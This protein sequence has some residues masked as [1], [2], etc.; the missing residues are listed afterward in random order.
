MQQLANLFT[1]TEEFS[2]T[3]GLW[4]FKNET[5]VFTNG[6]FDLLHPGHVQYLTDARALGSKLIVGLNTDASV[7]RQNKGPERPLQSQEAR[8]HILL[9]LRSVS[10]VI[11]FDDDTPLDLIKSI[12]PNILVKGAD[13]SVEATPTDKDYIVGKDEVIA[14]G[15]MV[16]TIPFLEGYSTSAIVNK[17]KL[18]G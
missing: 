1:N 17:I 11:L 16:K 13:Y 8:A 3:L 10:A 6:C 18:H 12:A 9:G 5:L 15:G 14:Q 7:K 4:R 2:K